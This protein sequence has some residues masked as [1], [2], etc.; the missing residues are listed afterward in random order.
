MI[1]TMIRPGRYTVV[2]GGYAY[3]VE[4]WTGMPGGDEGRV[5]RLWYVK[6]PDGGDVF[7]GDAVINDAQAYFDTL[8]EAVAHIE[9]LD[10]M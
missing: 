6:Y 1:V 4:R 10:V 3:G 8:K 5:Q 9:A 2:A 7:P